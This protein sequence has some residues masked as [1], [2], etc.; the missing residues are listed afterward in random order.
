T[1]GILVLAAIAGM[2]GYLVTSRGNGDRQQR[3]LLKGMRPLILCGALV[4]LFIV[5]LQIIPQGSTPDLKLAKANPRSPNKE[6]MEIIRDSRL[7]PDEL[8]QVIIAAGTN[9]WAE[10]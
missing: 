10:R 8:N 2:L 4:I 7:T 1:L 6:Q 9:S 5:I 3:W